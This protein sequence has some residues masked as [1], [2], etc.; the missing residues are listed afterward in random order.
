M[1]LSV[2]LGFVLMGTAAWADG[3]A[4]IAAPI[5]EA[6]VTIIGQPNDIPPNPT[7]RTSTLIFPPGAKTAEHKHAYPHYAIVQEGTLTVVDTQDNKTF[8]VKKGAFFLEM[9]DTWHYG[10]NKGTEPVKLL[11]V[12]L[13]PPQVQVNSIPKPAAP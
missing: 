6:S 2:F 4:L 13:V 1:K 3:P 9:I 8:E 5:G 11:I 12:D 10:V 7:V